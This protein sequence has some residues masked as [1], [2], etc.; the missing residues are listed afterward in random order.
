MEFS[1]VLQERRSYRSLQKTV[2]TEEIIHQLLEAA[3]LAPSCFNKQPWNFS[4]A[5]SEKKLNALKEIYSPG[6]EW[7]EH[8]SLVIGVYTRKQDDCIIKKREYALFDTGT[9]AA[10]L[11]LKAVDMGLCAHCIAGFHEEKGKVILEI[12]SDYQ[13]ITLIAISQRWKEGVEFLTQEQREIE[14][15][16]PKRKKQNQWSKIL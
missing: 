11:Q 3:S 1:E 15:N 2:I 14:L 8:A 9:A 5:V 6:N 4:C 16:R 13:L 7:M 10:F 12:P